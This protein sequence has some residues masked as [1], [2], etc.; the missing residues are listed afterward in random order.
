MNKSDKQ[1][2]RKRK[3]E[4]QYLRELKR[5]RLTKGTIKGGNRRRFGCP[6]RRRCTLKRWARE[7]E[8]Q[9]PSS[10]LVI[11][12]ESSRPRSTESRAVLWFFSSLHTHHAICFKEIYSVLLMSLLKDMQDPSSAR[13]QAFFGEILIEGCSY[14]W[15]NCKRIFQPCH[16]LFS[17]S[18][19]LFFQIFI[20]PIFSIS[21]TSTSLFPRVKY[22]FLT[23]IF[24]KKAYHWSVNSYRVLVAF[25]WMEREGMV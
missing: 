15:S 19:S 6:E 16:P 11:L 2:Y 13:S 4:D 10:S 7:E 12:H 20:I 21:I 23:L 8:K 1:C 22:F 25:F 18:F 14:S 24:A 9:S 3:R 5:K 17:A